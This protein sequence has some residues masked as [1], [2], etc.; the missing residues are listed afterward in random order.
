MDLA[1]SDVVHAF[2]HFLT[3]H[4]DGRPIIVASHSQ[5]T[6][7]AKRLLAHLGRRNPAVLERLVAAYLP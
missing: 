2:E 4:N 5:G 1:F 3:A 6:M 7:H